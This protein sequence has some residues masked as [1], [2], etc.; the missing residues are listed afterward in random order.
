MALC[1]PSG[2]VSKGMEI[3]ILPP[4]HLGPLWISPCKLRWGEVIAQI[5]FHCKRNHLSQPHHRAA[6]SDQASRKDC[7]AERGTCKTYRVHFCLFHLSVPHI[8]EEWV[9]ASIDHFTEPHTN[10]ASFLLSLSISLEQQRLLNFISAKEI[11]WSKLLAYINHSLP[12]NTWK[13]RRFQ[14]EKE[15]RKAAF[16]LLAYYLAVSQRDCWDLA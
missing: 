9:C 11:K 15:L 8:W 6:C 16:F 13:M 3:L 14:L 4:R 2:W 12:M 1:L 10:S 7:W 5:F